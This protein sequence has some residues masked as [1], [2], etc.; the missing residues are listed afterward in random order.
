MTRKALLALT[1]A[2]CIAGC[3][4]DNAPAPEPEDTASAAPVAAEPEASAAPASVP[5]LPG[6]SDKDPQTLLTYWKAAVEAHDDA[7]AAAAWREGTAP[8]PLTDAEVTVTFGEG[9]QEGAAGSLYFTVPV[10]MTASSP[11]GEAIES[12]ATLTARRVNDVPG[13]SE[14]Q[15]SWRIVSIESE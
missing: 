1:L 12:A 9:R 14:E 7:A 5:P 2:V 10:T 4:G 15:L 8:A 13:A 6:P 3:S 11:D